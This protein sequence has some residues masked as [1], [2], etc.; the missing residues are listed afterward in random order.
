MAITNEQFLKISGTSD[1]ISFVNWMEKITFDKQK[2]EQ[3]YHDILEIHKDMSVDFFRDYFMT[4]SAVSTTGQLYSPDELGALVS[5]LVGN[6][7][8]ADFTGAGT[9]TLIIQK[10]QYD[11]LNADFFNYRPSNFFYH[12]LELDDT[13]ILFLINAFAIRGM[14]GIIIHGDALE[15]K[16]KQVYFIQNSKDNALGFSDV[17]I[18]PHSDETSKEFGISEWLEQHKEHIESPLYLW[19]ITQEMVEV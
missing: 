6:Q 19:G 15:M 11:R 5:R 2:R 16:A 9:G 14:N 17:N 12:A 3:F 8:A 10:W 1:H 13:A 4:N 18:M 7:G